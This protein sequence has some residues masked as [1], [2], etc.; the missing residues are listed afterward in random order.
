MSINK[1]RISYTTQFSDSDDKTNFP[2]FMFQS[3][4]YPDITDT[5]RSR[6]YKPLR[7]NVPPNQINADTLPV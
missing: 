1:F 4:L 5:T 6:G 7:T 3:T 2:S